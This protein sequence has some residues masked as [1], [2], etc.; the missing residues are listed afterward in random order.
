MKRVISSMLVVF[1][2][3][4][5]VS[6]S[7]KDEVAD[8]IVQYYNEEWVPINAMEEEEMRHFFNSMYELEKNKKDEIISLIKNEPLP[9]VEESLK[10]L[11]S[12]EPKNKQIDKLNEMQINIEHHERDGLEA[13]IDYYEGDKSED[14]IEKLREEL[15]EKYDEIIDYRNDLMEKYNLEQD[16]VEEKIGDFYKLKRAEDNTD[17][18][19]R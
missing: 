11:E 13:I 4:L 10:R 14:E 2:L 9:V 19:K 17:T 7:N 6:C 3:S 16:K 15:N 18:L 12:L 5:L 8:E 1:A